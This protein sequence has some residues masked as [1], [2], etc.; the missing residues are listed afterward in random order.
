L[1]GKAGRSQ[2]P[3]VRGML[4]FSW[5]AK[6]RMR[7]GTG[8]A[9]S[10]VKAG[11]VVRSGK[12]PLPVIEKRALAE[13]RSPSIG[14]P[15]VARRGEICQWVARLHDAWKDLADMVKAIAPPIR[16]LLQMLEQLYGRQ[17][18]SPFQNAHFSRGGRKQRAHSD[19]DSFQLPASGGVM[20]G[21]WVALRRYRPSKMGPLEFLPRPSHKF[22]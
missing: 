18:A 16:P 15:P 1:H 4:L 17:A 22:A 7:S 19:T 20:C 8:H 3:I 2:S 14:R 21:I 11:F 5:I 10:S 6:W 13:P 12:F 9:V